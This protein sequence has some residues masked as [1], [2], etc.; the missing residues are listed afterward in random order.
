MRIHTQ[1]STLSF[2][3]QT[4]LLTQSVVADNFRRE[5]LILS[6]FHPFCNPVTAFNNHLSRSDR[7]FEKGP[8]NTN[9]H[10]A[11]QAPEFPIHDSCGTRTPADADDADGLDFR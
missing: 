5:P 1:R 7:A 2:T 10:T 4:A 6:T 9:Y 3:F 8:E 11:S